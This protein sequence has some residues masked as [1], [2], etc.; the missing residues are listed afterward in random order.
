MAKTLDEVIA[1]LKEERDAILDQLKSDAV[2]G[3]MPSDSFNGQAIDFV[4][5][6]RQLSDRLKEINE[7][8]L[9][10]EPFEFTQSAW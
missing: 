6:R 8:L 5:W 7:E 1:S 3:P 10:H 9:S 4:G 2:S